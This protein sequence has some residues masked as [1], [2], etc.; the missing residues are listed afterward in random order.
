MPCN[1]SWFQPIESQ[2]A[3]LH[4]TRMAIEIDFGE[5]AQIINKSSDQDIW[6][7]RP[8]S[9]TQAIG[10]RGHTMRSGRSSWTF[11]H[12]SQALVSWDVGGGGAK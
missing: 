10:G 3:N 4:L 11:D 8:G 6:L 7:F 5:A 9:A 12:A 2:L 1:S